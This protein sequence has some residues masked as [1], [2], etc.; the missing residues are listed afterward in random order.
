VHSRNND[1]W[2]TL[3]MV[4]A[5]DPAGVFALSQAI[6]HHLPVHVDNHPLGRH[7]KRVQDLLC[8]RGILICLVTGSSW[9]TI[10]AL[11]EYKVSDS[12]L[13]TRRNTGIAAGVFAELEAETRAGDDRIIGLDLSFVAVRAVEC[14]ADRD[15]VAVDADRPF[16]SVFASVNRARNGALT[17]VGGLY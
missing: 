5:L 16:V 4:S 11:M 3:I 17:G 13:R 7:R 6:Y 2:K 10:E 1:Q 15:S 12:T 8:F 9:E 14:P